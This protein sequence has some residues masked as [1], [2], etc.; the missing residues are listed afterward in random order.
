[1]AR[2]PA[3]TQSNTPDLSNVEESVLGRGTRVRGRIGGEGSLRVEG[4]IEGN[5]AVGGDLAVEEG[6]AITGD[7]EA[8]A[9]TI[10]GALTGDVSARGAIAIRATAKVAGNMGG[11]EVSLDEGASFTGRIEA[12]FDL[13]S[14]LVAQK[15]GR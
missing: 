10:H 9:V 15:G 6:A 3:A 12:E 14:E 11:S 1:M 13:P 5:V 4:Q 8:R 7:V 2:G